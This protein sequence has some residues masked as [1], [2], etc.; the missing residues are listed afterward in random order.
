MPGPDYILDV[1]GLTPRLGAGGA[2]AQPAGGT[3]PVAGKARA[4]IAVEWSCCSVYSR[5]YKHRDGGR[6]EGRCP[7]CMKLATAKV[8]AGGTNR[9]FFKAG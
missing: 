4:W 7:K 5:I 3:T 8:G 9:R 2:G 1:T 6:Y